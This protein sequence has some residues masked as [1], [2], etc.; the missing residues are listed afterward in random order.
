[1]L[2][3]HLMTYRFKFVDLQVKSFSFKNGSR[4]YPLHVSPPPHSPP[5]NVGSIRLVTENNHVNQNLFGRK[6]ASI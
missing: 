1:M 4:G 2:L 3:Y 6:G 5:F